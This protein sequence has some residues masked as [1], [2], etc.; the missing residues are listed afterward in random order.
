MRGTEEKG[1]D[2]RIAIDLIKLAWADDYDTAVLV[3][4]DKDF[5]PLVQFLETR[6]LKILHA[7]FLPQASHLA[8]SCWGRIN[9][10]RHRGAFHL[11]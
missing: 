3:S 2:V 8:N 11:T 1:V 7:G 9:I 10:P 5:I 6:G 4:A